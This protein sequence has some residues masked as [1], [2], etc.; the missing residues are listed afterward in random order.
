VFDC[1]IILHSTIAHELPLIISGRTKPE[2]VTIILHVYCE[3][4]ASSSGGMSY[5]P[6]IP[7]SISEK[8][9]VGSRI[10]DF[11]A[12]SGG[13]TGSMA[14]FWPGFSDPEVCSPPPPTYYYY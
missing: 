14:V 7:M 9:D 3:R 1:D 6:M 13:A 11:C 5:M 12:I 10:K 8:Q 4:S 2:P